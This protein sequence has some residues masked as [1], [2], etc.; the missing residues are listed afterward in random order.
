MNKNIEIS[1]I[2]YNFR[3]LIDTR[4]LDAIP[5][6][7]KNKFVNSSYTYHLGQCINQK[8]KQSREQIAN[9]EKTLNQRN[10]SHLRYKIQ[11]KFLKQPNSSLNGDSKINTFNTT[12]IYIKGQSNYFSIG[13]IKNIAVSNGYAGSIAVVEPPIVLNAIGLSDNDLA[14]LR[15]SMGKYN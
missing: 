1:Y 10:I 3:P 12:N 2:V 7:C 5:P 9:E 8:Y 15:F 6:F 4:V 13:K 14:T 11:T